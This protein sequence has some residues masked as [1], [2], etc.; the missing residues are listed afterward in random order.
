MP[1]EQAQVLQPLLDGQ[2][3]IIPDDLARIDEPPGPQPEQALAFDAAGVV[4][5][6]RLKL[7]AQP[8]HAQVRQSPVEHDLRG[9]NRERLLFVQGERRHRQRHRPGREELPFPAHLQPPAAGQRQRHIPGQRPDGTGQPHAARRADGHLPRAGGQIPL[10]AH[11]H[12]PLGSR[13]PHRV[14]VHPSQR[15]AIER[16]G[17][18]LS[19]ARQGLD[20]QAL[21]LDP[22]HPG[23][24]RQ[25]SG[26][27]RPADPRPARKKFQMVDGAGIQPRALDENLPARDAVVGQPAVFPAG[28][29][30]GQSEARGVEKAAPVA[31][32]AVLVDEDHLRGGA[33]HFGDAVEQG[34]IRAE[35]FVEDDLRAAAAQV[36]VGPDP[37]A[38]G[39]LGRAGGDVVEDET[40]GAD[41][42]VLV[43]VVRD[44]RGV[45]GGD[46]DDGH[47]VAGVPQGA[48]RGQLRQ[49]QRGVAGEAEDEDTR[50]GAHP[51]IGEKAGGGSSR[52]ARG[53]ATQME[54]RERERGE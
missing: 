52:R 30:R 27:K 53:A 23:D 32:D 28:L 38:Q 12:A 6:C 20:G 11:A 24:D 13:Q 35:D 8:Q 25:L 46:V 42:V 22:V 3:H 15:A 34:A 43:G 54:L 31:G 37:A 14:G 40:F 44:A 50:D 2:R 5:G 17:R 10:Q 19:V 7:S 41:V 48:G 26:V 33:S 21:G 1:F 45:G 18:P 51:A 39:A 9:R 36:R 49:A 16:I 4:D 29:A 47:I